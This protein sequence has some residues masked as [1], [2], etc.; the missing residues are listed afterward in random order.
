MGFGS[1]ATRTVSKLTWPA[2]VFLIFVLVVFA[3]IQ[4]FDTFGGY[5]G[6]DIFATRYL[7]HPVIAAIHIFC[8][9]T[10]ILFAPF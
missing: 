10:F 5:A 6:D 4:L 3:G 2:V 1:L 7:Q 9:V 8:G